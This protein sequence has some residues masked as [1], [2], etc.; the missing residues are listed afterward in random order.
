MSCLGDPSSDSHGGAQSRRMAEIS[1]Y[2]F[3]SSH[4][5]LVVSSFFL[6]FVLG[7]SIR[8]GRSIL[9]AFLPIKQVLR[10]RGGGRRS[11]QR[12]LFPGVPK[13]RPWGSRRQGRS[14]VLS[15]MIFFADGSPGV[16]GD[17]IAMITE[18]T[19]CSGWH[20]YTPNEI[21]TCKS[22]LALAVWMGVSHCPT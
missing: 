20:L 3:M 22:C 7:P 13:D 8:I 2:K 9:S 14:K 1:S 17:K 18:N 15:D 5:Q 11:L 6:L 21:K 16:C 12:W 19:H 4:V 10:S